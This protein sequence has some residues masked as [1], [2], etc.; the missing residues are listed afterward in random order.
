MICDNF[1][2][3]Q[4]IKQYY[5]SHTTGASNRYPVAFLSIKIPPDDL[6]VNLEPNKTSAMLTNKDE[7]MSLLSNLLEEFYSDEKNKISERTKSNPSNGTEKGTATSKNVTK[8]VV[9]G[10]VSCVQTSSNVDAV[11][12]ENNVTNSYGSNGKVVCK[13]TC[14][15]S[16]KESSEHRPSVQLDKNSLFESEKSIEHSKQTTNNSECHLSNNALQNTTTNGSNLSREKSL[17][18]ETTKQNTGDKDE[19]KSPNSV[20]VG[21]VTNINGHVDKT[22]QLPST[23]Q[24]DTNT[25]AQADS[26]L[27]SSFDSAELCDTI[28]GSDKSLTEII[29]SANVV[30]NSSENVTEQNGMAENNNESSD[31]H[32]SVNRDEQSKSNETSV[33]N[34]N[35]SK[36]IN[37]DGCSEKGQDPPQNREFTCT[38]SMS[39]SVKNLFSLD[40]DDLFNDSDLDVTVGDS[41]LKACM[42]SAL[43]C[44]QTAE[45]SK[46]LETSFSA[47]N[48]SS[49]SVEKSMTSAPFGAAEARCSDKEWSMGSGIVDKQG[50]PVEVL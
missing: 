25:L 9:N 33:M 21:A 35:N 7:V 46:L 13:P 19:C 41:C 18:D 31:N 10:I 17:C 45:K 26:F 16:N 23:C 12:G 11:I 20:E 3:S 38:A 36:T 34:G 44:V 8:E 47:T 6:D 1:F 24:E 14:S 40:L 28:T 32:W 22:F 43:N 4:L 39:Q 27:T 49:V 30:N 2:L 37:H 15:N 29:D 5:N 42:S 48:K 50:K